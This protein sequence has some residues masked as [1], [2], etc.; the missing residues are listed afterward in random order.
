MSLIIIT[1]ICSCK[2]DNKSGR[3]EVDYNED[4][5]YKTQ[6]IVIRVNTNYIN[7]ERKFINNYVYAYRLDLNE[8]LIGFCGPEFVMR[9]KE[10]II[11]MVNKKDSLDSFVGYRGIID[12]KMLEEFKENLKLN[13]QTLKN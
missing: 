8:P 6:G 12:K 3:N 1:I 4:D 13:E 2:N 7:F 5:Y 10:P 9:N 11:V